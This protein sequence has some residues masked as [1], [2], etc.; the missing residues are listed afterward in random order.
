MS[1]NLRNLFLL[2]SLAVSL[3]NQP[4]REITISVRDESM[5]PVERAVFEVSGKNGQIHTECT[6]GE[7]GTCSI[8]APMGSVILTLRGPFHPTTSRDLADDG[9]GFTSPEPEDGAKWY[10]PF[11]SAKLSISVDLVSN[12]AKARSA[13][14][15]LNNVA[16]RLIQTGN[17]QK[18][19]EA[20]QRAVAAFNHVAA[21]DRRL[22][23]LLDGL[24]TLTLAG[25]LRQHLGGGLDRAAEHL[26]KA[27]A[28]SREIADRGYEP[29]TRVVR[30]SDLLRARV[31]LNIQLGR[32]EDACTLIE[33]TAKEAQWLAIP[34]ENPMLASEGDVQWWSED[35]LR[36]EFRD[37][38]L[39]IALRV[40]KPSPRCA[41]VALDLLLTGKGN[42]LDQ[43]ARK[44][45]WLRSGLPDRF[46]GLVSELQSIWDQQSLTFI[47]HARS[48]VGK[49]DLDDYVKTPPWRRNEQPR[50]AEA[51]QRD[52]LRQRESALLQKLLPLRRKTAAVTSQVGSRLSAIQARIPSDTAVVEFCRYLPYTGRKVESS[53]ESIFDEDRYAAFVIQKDRKPVLVDLGESREADDVAAALVDSI[54]VV[55]N[56]LDEEAFTASL[57]DFRMLSR[58][59]AGAVFDPIAPH[60]N[61]VSHIILGPDRG[62]T[63]IPFAALTLDSGEYLQER[64]LV[65][66]IGS[67]NDLLRLSETFQRRGPA[68][69]LGLP[70]FGPAS[71]SQPDPFTAETVSRTRTEVLSIR[72]LLN[73]GT[74]YLG[75]T[76]TKKVVQS[77][78]GPQVFHLATHAVSGTRPEEAST[79]DY[80]ARH[81]SAEILG[82]DRSLRRK[83]ERPEEH[84]L[85]SRIALAG[86]NVD[87][88]A[89]VLVGAEV[90][91]LDLYKTQIAV[92]SACVTGVGLV[93][94]E[95]GSYSLR[96]ALTIAGSQTQITT[97]WSVDD[98]ATQQVMLGFYQRIG[99]GRGEA[100]RHAQRTLANGPDARLRHPYYWAAFQLSGNWIPLKLSSGGVPARQAIGR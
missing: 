19:I 85:R 80:P 54:V 44:I 39:S 2:A 35:S 8:T 23:V 56:P 32:A 22:P 96:R 5:Q 82:I 90:S 46:Q 37:L 16:T 45:A 12:V 34:D 71:E 20:S 40:E 62:L 6:T 14:F 79:D 95:E 30:E 47:D 57:E 93:R 42:V 91:R 17:Y 58:R 25:S 74:V 31:M 66:Y 100:L 24:S 67:A 33:Q 21:V 51:Q 53:E 52:L 65:T 87:P 77:V 92:L 29:S 59:L 3:Q 84:L 68:F 49:R 61:G 48:G 26:D 89:G 97:L 63:V 98:A 36:E 28:L 13:L 7:D 27:T 11:G 75:A 81:L 94:E 10:I 38:A 41:Q 4:T 50:S 60:L 86:A 88:K 1:I 55:A 83:P 64:M 9:R 73:E 78:R 15:D 72:K 18:G 70:D 43:T 69:L 76:A 99:R